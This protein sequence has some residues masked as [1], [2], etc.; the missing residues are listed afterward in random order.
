MVHNTYEAPLYTQH[1]SHTLSMSFLCNIEVRNIVTTI[2]CIKDTSI[3]S[4]SL[5]TLYKLWALRIL[6]VQ[7]KCMKI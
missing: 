3:S 2:C 5:G 6:Y 7:G 1:I 4:V